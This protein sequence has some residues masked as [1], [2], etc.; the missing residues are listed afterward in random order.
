MTGFCQGRSSIFHVTHIAAPVRLATGL[1]EAG[2]AVA[3]AA[4]A[5]FWGPASFGHLAASAEEGCE[6]DSGGTNSENG[7][8]DVLA[9][10]RTTA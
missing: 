10:V 6:H 1:L 8:E 3:A 7:I 4:G 2:D 5:G 9:G